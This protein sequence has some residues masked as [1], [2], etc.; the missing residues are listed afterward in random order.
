MYFVTEVVFFWIKR[1]I[2]LLRESP[3]RTLKRSLDSCTNF[4]EWEM[5]TSEIDRLNGYDVWR[6]NFISKKYDYRLINERLHD[7]RLAR[8]N[9]D[10]LK[11]MGTLRSGV[12]RNFGG[13]SNKQLYN[14][15]YIGTKVLIEDYIEEVLKCF[16]FIDEWQLKD[17]TLELNHF[18]QMKLD[19]FH[20]TRQTLGVTALIL[21]GGSLFG[22][23]HLGVIKALYSKNLLPRIIAG[24]SIGALVGALICCLDDNEIEDNLNNLVNLLPQEEADENGTS[25]IASVVRKGYSQDM[26]LFIKYVES[27]VGD[28]TF[29]EAYL[30]TNRILNILIHPT[31]SCA[32]SLLNYISTPNVTILSAIYCSIGNSVQEDDVQLKFKNSENQIETLQFLKRHCEY[33]SP[34]YASSISTKSFTPISP[35]T[36]LTELFNV[37]HFV[38]ALARPYLAPLIGNDLKHSPT[39]WQL[40]NHIK[41]LIS[42]EL[43]HRMETLEKF[44]LLMGFFRWLAVDEKTPRFE[45]SE[46]TIVP[47]LRTLI[48]DFSRIFDV[49]KYKENIPYWIQ[50]GERSVWPL[51]PLLDT[52][53]AIEFALDDYYNLHRSSSPVTSTARPV[54]NGR[55]DI[56]RF[57]LCTSFVRKDVWMVAKSSGISEYSSNDSSLELI[58][59]RLHFAFS[60]CNCNN[61][62]STL[63]SDRNS[64][65]SG[66]SR[67]TFGFPFLAN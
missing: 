11:V 8:I 7:L 5:I 67:N 40:T 42:L 20:D 47:E 30:K 3:I 64:R 39:S 37:N 2:K 41:N 55:K 27:K 31:E 57:D 13:I 14:K 10:L 21:Q 38:V 45:N 9:E 1:L 63:V 58:R 54:F 23:C 33:I 25:V 46:I 4:H 12:L 32:P 24:S 15:S 51:Y 66:F 29:E 35:Y 65:N 50:V 26:L 22:L 56:S 43:R 53:C 19:F 59:K 61:K 16:Q 6:Q 34:H 52:R 62:V 28:L 44:G 48:R 49:N 60:F 36:R 17:N 18:N